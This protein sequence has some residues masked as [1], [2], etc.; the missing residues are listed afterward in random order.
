METESGYGNCMKKIPGGPLE[1]EYMC[2]VVMPSSCSDLQ[3]SDLLSNYKDYQ[4]KKF[5]VIAC[6]GANHGIIFLQYLIK[7]GKCNRILIL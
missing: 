2:Y 3:T 6:A 1:G 5:S 4:T 7:K